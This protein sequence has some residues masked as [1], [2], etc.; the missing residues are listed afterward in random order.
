MYAALAPG[1]GGGL[2]AKHINDRRLPDKAID[3]LDEAGARDRM[4]AEPAGATAS[5]RAT[6]SASSR[7]SRR[8][9]SG[10]SRRT[11]RYGSQPRP[12]AQRRSSTG[13]DRAV[14]AI[15][16]HH[17]A[18]AFRPRRAERPIG[19]FLFSG[20]TGVGKTELAKQL[21]RILGVEFLRFDMTEYPGGSTPS[22]GSSA[23][24]R[25]TSAS[26][27]AGSSPMRSARPRTPCSSSTRSR[28]R[29]RTSTTCSCR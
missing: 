15:V 9:R 7:R 22:R 27:R 13:Q 12:R 21:A 19:G 4:R 20:P 28:R 3:V 14:Q 6:W 8:S 10:P 26:T 24:R 2:S 11:T 1:S 17:Q 18:L 16:S 25:D 5:P 29:T 23:R